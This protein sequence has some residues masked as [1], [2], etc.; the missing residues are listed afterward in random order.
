MIDEPGCTAGNAISLSPARGPML[1]SLRSLATFPSSI[2]RRR[3]A[4]EY[5]SDVPHALRH[6]KAI[7]RRHDVDIDARAEILHRAAAELVPRVE[8]GAHRRGAQVHLL[9]L[10]CRPHDIVGTAVDAG[11]VAAELLAERHRHGVLKVGSPDFEDTGEV[12]RLA[13]QGRRQGSCRRR[14]AVRARAGARPVSPMGTRRWWTVPCS[15]DRW[16]APAGTRP[17]LLRAAH[18]PG[19]PA[20]R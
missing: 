17:S 11:G 19:W 6:A 10:F 13:V 1:R 14:Q 4:P 18:S 15:R 3:I 5:A 12:S 16:D 2:A 20:P 9:Q 8:P 7:R